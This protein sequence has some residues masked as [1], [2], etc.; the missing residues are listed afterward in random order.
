MTHVRRLATPPRRRRGPFARPT[1]N[2]DAVVH[3]Y[4]DDLGLPILAHWLNHDGYDGVVF[5]LPDARVQMELLRH[6]DRIP[7][8]HPENQL[9]LYLG[10]PEAVRSATRRLVDR[11]HRPVPAANPYWTA[12]R[13]VCFEDPDGWVVVLVPEVFGQGS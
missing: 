3:F 2:F 8:P 5:G 9:V 12:H 1:A 10:T 7:E 13:A 6:G 4:G 11:G